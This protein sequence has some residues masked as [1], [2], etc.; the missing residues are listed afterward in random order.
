MMTQ[1]TLMDEFVEKL[2]LMSVNNYL[3]KYDEK[4]IKCTKCD[5]TANSYLFSKGCKNSTVHFVG[6]VTYITSCWN[7]QTITILSCKT[8]KNIYN[9]LVYDNTLDV[10][11]HHNLLL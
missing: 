7:G 11:N 3:W 9:I 1:T 10:I 2:C 4:V 8:L 5:D 6:N